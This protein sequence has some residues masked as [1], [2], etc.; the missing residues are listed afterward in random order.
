MPGRDIEI[1]GGAQLERIA[2]A[3]REVDPMLRREL[4]HD[5]RALGN[6]YVPKVRAAID[7]IPAKHAGSRHPSLRAAMKA[8]TRV[9]IRTLGPQ[10]GM[11]IRVDGRKMPEGM[12][13]LPKYMEGIKP[14]RH[15]VFGD[16]K[17]WVEES[18]HPYFFKTVG[19]AGEEFR[20]DV[21]AIAQKIAHKLQ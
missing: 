21:N 18:S 4:V 14:W 20:R 17:D 16:R 7:Q 19:P 2:K 9:Q 5:L 15:P 8:A 11:V 13:S 12:R 6:R 1:V 3:L 10:T